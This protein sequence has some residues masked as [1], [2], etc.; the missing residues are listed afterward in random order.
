MIT[1]RLKER[2]L[3][4]GRREGRRITR[5]EISQATGVSEHVLSMMSGTGEYHTTTR[6][7]E[8]LCRYFGCQVGDLVVLVDDDDE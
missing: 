5:A 3:D 2:I 1:Y 7:I 6:T 4:R 8:A